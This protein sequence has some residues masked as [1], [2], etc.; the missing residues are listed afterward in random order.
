MES[1]VASTM[2][3]VNPTIITKTKVTQAKEVTIAKVA[4]ITKVVIITKEVITS[5]T[6]AGIN[7]ININISKDGTANRIT[8]R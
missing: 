6:G 4:T 8:H 3:E 7:K 1:R 2:V 5:K